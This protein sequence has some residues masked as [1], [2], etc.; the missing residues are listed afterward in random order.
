MADLR[1]VF[2]A[3]TDAYIQ[4]LRKVVGVNSYTYNQ[5]GV[6][7]VGAL[8]TS[9]FSELGFS[10]KKIRSVDSR[11]GHHLITEHAGKSPY[12]IILLSHLDTVFPALEEQEN[13]FFWREEGDKIF[14]PGVLDIKGGSL[15]IYFYLKV[16]KEHY[17]DVFNFFN[18]TILHNA[19]EEPG[20]S[21]FA[22]IARNTVRPDSIACLVY[23]GAENPEHQAGSIICIS[24]RGTARF[25][26]EAFG[27]SGHSGSSHKKGVNSVRELCRV[28]EIIEQL[29][30]YEKDITFSVGVIKG[31]T[32]VNTI[33]SY[34]YC[35]VDV[36]ANNPDDF[37]WA[38]QQILNLGG[39][40]TLK[41]PLDGFQSQIKV[42]RQGGFPPWPTTELNKKISDL[43]KSVCEKQGRKLCVQELRGGTSDGNFMYDLLPTI[44]LLGPNGSNHHCSIQSPEKGQ[45]Q[46]YIL[47]SSI[48]PQAELNI[49][50]IQEIYLKYRDS[51]S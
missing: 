35:L 43:I 15:L 48:I 7:A 3:E 23:E 13:N 2:Q 36:R 8:F 40:G 45:E 26:I 24:R 31:G 29:T 10:T 14:G 6:D 12:H 1:H 46:E 44:D 17:P 50:L 33:P 22:E 49:K 20:G 34:A 27:R 21:D 25:K 19:T 28:V 41:S 32:A 9:W 4:K 18:W 51:N 38:K 16:L 30:N 11:C 37:D 42:N 5:K 47:K 39:A